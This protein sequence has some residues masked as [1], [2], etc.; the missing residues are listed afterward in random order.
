ML[1]QLQSRLNALAGDPSDPFTGSI[2][3]LVGPREAVLY[4]R[5]MRELILAMPAMTRQIRAWITGGNFQPGITRLHG[6]AMSYLYSPED[7]LPETSLGLFGYLDDA[8]LL[9]RVYHRTLLEADCLAGG[10]LPA[11]APKPGIVNDW[12]LLAKQLLPRETAALDKMLDE[13]FMTRTGNYAELLVKAAS[14]GRV[15]ARPSAKPA[16]QRRL[17]PPERPR[18]EI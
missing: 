11:D 15:R 6:F 2:R 1:Q 7:L 10:C 14:S 4:E 3:A 12:L 13:V 9:A 8:Y 5:P 18:Q 17:A 16:V